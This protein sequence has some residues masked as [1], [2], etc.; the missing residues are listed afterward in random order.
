[1][2]LNRR[3]SMVAVLSGSIFALTS[4]LFAQ[5]PIGDPA[6]EFGLLVM[7]HGGGAVWNREVETMLAP[8]RHDYVLE[9][10]FG[11]ADA[12]SLQEGVRKLEA[13]GV[14][15]IG[16]VRLFISGESWYQRT[17]QI[18]GLRPGAPARP[19]EDAHAGHGDHAGHSMAFWQMDTNAAF[20]LSAQG[21]AEAPEMGAVLVERAQALSRD[22]HRESV[23]IIAHGPQNDAE[24]Q[25][26]LA[27]IGTRAEAVRQAAPF[28]RVQVET[29]REDWPEKRAASEARIRAF[30]EHAT[31]EGGV[32]IV[33]PYRVQGF[34]PYAEVLE[35]L[36]Y[37]SDGR[38]LLPSAQVE[39]WVR[40]QAAELRA[41][42]FRAPER[43]R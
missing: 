22:P 26:W 6:H 28:R 35:G 42:S 12:V 39:Q 33:I 25:T 37:V 14:R 16:V 9:I 5:V 24:D 7:A 19:R 3:A 41:G 11:M 34:G 29:L 17:E 32:A 27:Q 30:V 4:S 15:R 18:L 8:L 1:M 2:S 21:L 38:A 36:T 43:A 20:A 23:L 13:Q 40:R 10:A 31:R